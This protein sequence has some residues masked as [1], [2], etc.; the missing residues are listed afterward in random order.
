MNDVKNAVLRPTAVLIQ[1]VNPDFEPFSNEANSAMIKIN[2]N[3]KII[4][5]IANAKDADNPNPT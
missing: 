1:D 5:A 4:T 2:G 3:R